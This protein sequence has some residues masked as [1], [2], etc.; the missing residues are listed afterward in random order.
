M[1]ALY[2]G[3]RRPRDSDTN[4]WGRFRGQGETIS[5]PIVVA[6]SGGVDSSTV[7]ALLKSRGED[8][9]G[10]G[11]R[12]PLLSAEAGGRACCGA[13]A[14]E[15][16]RRVA[17]QL[18]ISFAA[19]DYREIFSQS[20]VEYF[21]RSYAENQTPNPCVE[22]NRVIKFGALLEF[23]K[24]M[25]ARRLATGHYAIIEYDSA[26]GR[27]ILKKG[28]DAQHDQSYFLYS[29]SQEQLANALFPLGG[30]TKEE[31][32][33]LARKFGLPTAAKPGSQDICFLGDGDYRSLL[34]E[35]F[36]ESLQEGDIV[37]TSGKVLG[38]H[39]GTAR[40]TIG[41]RKSL[42]VAVGAPRYVVS[43][44]P[45]THTVVIGTKEE[46]L[47]RRIMV[48]NLNWIAFREPPG[49]MEVK[50]K[51]RYRQTEL[52]AKVRSCGDGMAEVVFQKPEPAAAPGQSAVF[53]DGQVVVGGGIIE[54][55]AP[56][57]VIAAV[58]IPH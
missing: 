3:L 25:G 6:M 20:V 37:D 49:E 12:L 19:L 22:C 23:A 30:M 34:A 1:G 2:T 53:Y 24:K 17:Q 28:I 9:V 51:I 57:A 54:S 50:V 41:Q 38:R 48:R 31:T 47:I 5:A 21:L 40:Y 52:P 42:G 26:R 43:I 44:S 35:R 29:L 55:S 32:R 46:M 7:A 18:G 15:D 39:R 13:D 36:P 4:S 10:V 16:A 58:V 8:V 14:M 56:P 33:E 27:H 11:M 45:G